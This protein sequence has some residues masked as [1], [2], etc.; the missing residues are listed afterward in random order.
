MRSVRTYSIA[1]LER[2]R[3]WPRDRCRRSPRSACRTP[4]RGRRSASS[5]CWPSY[6]VEMPHRLFVTIISS[7]SSLPLRE[8]HTSAVAK[9][10]SAVPASPP[11]TIVMPFAPVPLRCAR[12]V[13]I[14]IEN[15]TSIG[16]VT[17]TTFHLRT[18]EVPGEV[19]APRVRVGRRV[20]HLAQRIDRIRA[21]REQRA[22]RAVV[23]V[24]VVVVD[25]HRPCRR[26]ARAGR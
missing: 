26:A 24:Q 15:C 20:L 2:A 18:R 5:P 23:Q 13:P 17:G 11:C 12:A 21:H 14:A 4:C 22:A 3:S 25:A 19:A 10:P 1:F 9:S 8:L 6:G 16:D 7:G